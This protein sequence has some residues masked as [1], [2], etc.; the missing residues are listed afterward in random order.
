MSIYRSAR[1][2]DVAASQVRSAA[3]T[4]NSL[5]SQLHAAG[6]WTGNDA[7][8]FVSEWQSDVTDRLLRSASRID[9]LVFTRIGG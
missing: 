7:S 4:M 1:D 9:G 6:V 3:T 2:A 5:I 8:R